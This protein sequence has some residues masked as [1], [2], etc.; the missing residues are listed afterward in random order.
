MKTFQKFMTESADAERDKASHYAQLADQHQAH[1][2]VHNVLTKEYGKFE[3][4]HHH[5]KK[6]AD[7]HSK[8]SHEY[9]ALSSVH[10]NLWHESRKR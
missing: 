5:H 1:A 2:E 10:H 9:A 7:M 6:L 8:I 4:I 3:T